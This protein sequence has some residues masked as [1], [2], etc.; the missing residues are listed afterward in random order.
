MNPLAWSPWR[1]NM[2][3]GL[4]KKKFYSSDRLASSYFFIII[5]IQ[6]PPTD[7]PNISIISVSPTEPLS[8]GDVIA[9]SVSGGDPIV[10]SVIF[11]C[12]D[13]TMEDQVNYS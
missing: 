3:I 2:C 9:C 12:S 10:T 5:I 8:H 13:P 1:P 4:Q 6:D 11:Q 7:P